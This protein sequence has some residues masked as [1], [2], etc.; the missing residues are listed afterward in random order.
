M[1]G[2]SKTENSHA[3]TQRRKGKE[4]FA[5]AASSDLYRLPNEWNQRFGAFL[6][7]R[8]FGGELLLHQFV[9][10]TDQVNTKEQP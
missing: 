7:A 1:A 9:F 5:M 6:R 8:V 10:R 4:G 2:Q 3:K